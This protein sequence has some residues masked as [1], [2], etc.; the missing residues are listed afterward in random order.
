MNRAM[1][2]ASVTMGQ[3]QKKID[4]IGQNLANT[5]TNGFKKRET[6][7]NDLLFQQ[8]NNQ[9][10]EDNEIGRRTPNG[11]RLGTGAKL[12]ET[13]LR[14]EQGS[15]KVTDRTLDVALK[16]PNEF[17]QVM[18]AENG[19][20]LPRYTRDGAFYLSPEGDG[21]NALV[22][23]TGDYVLDGEG[24]PIYLPEDYKS[25]T[26]TETGE[27][28]VTYPDNT[29]ESLGE[30]QLIRVMRP[31][32]LLSAGDNQYVLPNLEELNLTEEEVFES[33]A[34]QA[35]SVQQGT[36]EMSNVDIATEMTELMIAQRSYQ[37][38]AKSIS[39][40]DQMAGLITSLR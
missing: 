27:I 24:N 1:L 21:T 40:A 8:I 26:F 28:V 11:I 39:I 38:N 6:S 37:F 4:T 32:L 22:T 2:T 9:A 16:R 20:F 3:L 5:N 25:L 14:M 19:Q 13:N 15:I 17:F 23:A 30:L 29:T 12:S 35:G 7:F 10:H 36:L 18:T 33:V 34:G 31:Q